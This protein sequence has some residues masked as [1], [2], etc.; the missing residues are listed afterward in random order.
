MYTFYHQH[1]EFGVCSVFVFISGISEMQGKQRANTTMRSHIKMQDR[2]P[3]HGKT[4]ITVPFLAHYTSNP[5]TTP[6][7][8][9]GES[10]LQL[11][12][13][14]SAKFYNKPMQPNRQKHYK[15]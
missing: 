3:T 12:A 11:P 5:H 1:R 2:D 10:S 4:A 6:T 14:D 13:R 15:N 7:H 8:P 9:Q